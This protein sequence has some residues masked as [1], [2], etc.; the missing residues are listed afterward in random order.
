MEALATGA[1]LGVAA[2]TGFLG[3]VPVTTLA[4]EVE[5]PEVTAGVEVGAV[6]TAVVAAAFCRSISPRLAGPHS[7]RRKTCKGSS[8]RRE[9]AESLAPEPVLRR[10]TQGK[11]EIECR[12][13]PAHFRPQ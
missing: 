10:L 4:A 13:P 1:R 8:R 6:D 2:R 3:M 12:Q 7:E 11:I 9:S 5:G